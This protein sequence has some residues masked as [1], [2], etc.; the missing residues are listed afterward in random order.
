MANKGYWIEVSESCNLIYNETSRDDH[1]REE[2]SPWE[3][4]IYPN[5]T[6]VIYAEF[7][8]NILDVSHNQDYLGVFAGDQCLGSGEIHLYSEGAEDK[9]VAVIVTQMPSAEQTITFAYYQARTSETIQLDQH[10]TVQSSEIYGAV[11][12]NLVQINY[13]TT[14]NTSNDVLSIDDLLITPSVNPFQNNLTIYIDS[15]KDQAAE[16]NL[17]NLKGQKV[18]TKHTKLDSHNTRDITLNTKHL[19]S[20]IYFV[21]V[22]SCGKISTLK[23]LK[24]K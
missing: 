15:K 5:N 8:S 24:I 9:N 12:D 21:K 16:V 4:T 13:F 11:P 3:I 14:E 2:T 6:A 17:Y 23:L 10:L 20:G 18:A 22:K 7:S 19:A 1:C